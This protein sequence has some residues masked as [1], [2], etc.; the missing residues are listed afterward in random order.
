MTGTRMPRLVVVDDD[1]ELA[2]ELAGLFSDVGYEVTGVASAAREGIDLVD[3]TMPDV[4]LM[5]VR[6]EGMSGTEAAGVLRRHYPG[7]PVVL[8]SAYADE[9]IVEAAREA[10]VAAY[11]VKGCTARELLSTVGT[12]VKESRV[13]GARKPGGP[14]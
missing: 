7:L 8:L 9:G 12:V 11:L 5:D 6:M 4:V 1:N 3:R 2:Q 14:D 13:K 10:Q